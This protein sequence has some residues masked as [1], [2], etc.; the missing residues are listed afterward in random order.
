MESGGVGVGACEHCGGP[1][2]AGGGGGGGGRPCVGG[3]GGGGGGWVG[4]GGGGRGGRR[5]GGGGVAGPAR[6]CS[7]ACVQAAAH[8]RELRPVPCMRVGCRN[9]A[10]TRHA[11]AERGVC[12]EHKRGRRNREWWMQVVRRVVVCDACGSPRVVRTQLKH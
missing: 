10:L 1:V 4:R 12:D 8:E 2:A 5:R 11:T 6:L 7:E 9:V 3:A